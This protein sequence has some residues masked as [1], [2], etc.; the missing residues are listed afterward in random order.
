MR[1]S[2]EIPENDTIPD[3]I[4]AVPPAPNFAG[5][6]LRGPQIAALTG[7][8]SWFDGDEQNEGSI[9]MGHVIIPMGSGK[10]ALGV[11]FAKEAIEKTGQ[12]VLVL[13]WSNNTAQGFYTACTDHMSANPSSHL[14]PDL[15]LGGRKA[16]ASANFIVSNFTATNNWPD[17]SEVG[18]ILVDEADINGLSLNRSAGLTAIARD[19][20]IPIV[21]L[22]ATD[23][24]ASRKCIEEVFPD[25]LI[26]MGMP[27]SLIPLREQGLVPEM[28]F[29]DI[30]LKANIQISASGEEISDEETGTLLGQGWNRQILDFYETHIRGK[31]PAPKTA[32]IYKNNSLLE[33]L[34]SQAEKRGIK[35]AKL[36]GDEDQA[37][38]ERIKADLESGAIDGVAGSRKLG[39]GTDIPCIDTVFDSQLTKS[40][41]LFWQGKGRAFRLNY[42]QEDKRCALY[43][44]IPCEVT[45]ENKGP[46]DK[47]EGPLTH[48]SYFDPN[49][50]DRNRKTGRSTSLRG[51]A[52]YRLDNLTDI[53]SSREVM[54][55]KR[56]YRGKPPDFISFSEL[57]AR[58]IAGIQE[59][60][61]ERIFF[62]TGRRR[63]SDEER[64]EM[65]MEP[66][67]PMLWADKMTRSEER[68][69][70]IKAIAEDDVAMEKLLKANLPV[71]Q[72]IAALLSE[73]PEIRDELVQM[74]LLKLMA[75][76]ERYDIS[77][78]V[79]LIRYTIRTLYTA[80]WRHA[81]QYDTI[82]NLDVTVTSHEKTDRLK[83]WKNDGKMLDRRER[84]KALHL[85]M[86]VATDNHL[87][88]LEN[89]ANGTA[90]E[91]A[92]DNN[93]STEAPDM[94][95]A[96]TVGE[97]VEI[98]RNLIE[99][100]IEVRNSYV[101]S[102][103]F[104]LQNAG[105]PDGE[106]STHEEIGSDM[107]LSRSRVQ[108]IEKTALRSWRNTYEAAIAKK[109]SPQAVAVDVLKGKISGGD[110]ITQLKTHIQ[111]Q[112]PDMFMR[113][114]EQ[115]WTVEA[116]RSEVQTLRVEL[117]GLRTA[118]SRTLNSALTA[119]MDED[120]RILFDKFRSLE[121]K[122]THTQNDISCLN[123][124]LKSLFAE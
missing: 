89:L 64:E 22:S 77:Q 28:D 44:F 15:A 83:E 67:K 78:R 72:A 95:D 34:I 7:F 113:L 116:I 96:H 68:D 63:W 85:K 23:Q 102:R 50:Y 104:G 12:K 119:T 49:Y 107:G 111:S 115:K 105:N 71:I 99:S 19:F 122:I 43:N 48:G 87:S 16:D 6:K 117:K 76:I 103:R 9:K 62:V 61:A 21:A 112:Y 8:S 14:I 59:E 37:D 33:D 58:K 20:G 123:G 47:H 79:R 93:L 73:K 55:E 118:R 121:S 106:E 92:S 56:D 65:E 30:E 4:D 3:L 66:D 57:L 27:N 51:S 91:A 110:F 24:L 84:I 86:A 18:L 124:V 88:Q 39:R 5:K 120:T 1:E 69:N 10:T 82:S 114:N 100:S 109:L 81:I 35:L 74:G 90:E 40:P 41:Q 2:S 46:A 17:L 11:L 53:R 13:S 25:E 31:T 94:E 54:Q 32:F 45:V 36:T 26:Y 97:G 70:L 108:Y 52:H 80:M 38:F 101:L 98:I 75:S 29:Y 42:R 60:T